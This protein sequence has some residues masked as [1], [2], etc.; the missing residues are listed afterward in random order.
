MDE[1]RGETVSEL[2][3]VGK[4]WGGGGGGETPH[5]RL[6]SLSGNS[7]LLHAIFGT[8]INSYRM[9]LLARKLYCTSCFSSEVT[10]LIVLSMP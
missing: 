8:Q 9:T 1:G 2:L 6:E 5:Y 4:G 3:K 10:E 7:S